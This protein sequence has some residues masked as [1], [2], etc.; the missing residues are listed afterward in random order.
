[1]SYLL[2]VGMDKAINNL[3]V[4]LGQLKEEIL[5]SFPVINAA[6]ILKLLQTDCFWNMAFETNCVTIVSEWT[7][8]YF[9]DACTTSIRILS[10]LVSTNNIAILYKWFMHALYLKIVQKCPNEVQ[11]VK[12]LKE[13]ILID[14][15]YPSEESVDVTYLSQ[16]LVS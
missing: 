3:S 1:M 15:T 14:V 7:F 5:V 9:R 8:C 16:E 11:S 13:W 12:C 2:Q 10:S 6:Y 4:P